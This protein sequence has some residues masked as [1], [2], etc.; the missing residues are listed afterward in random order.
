[1]K[2]PLYKSVNFSHKNLLNILWIFILGLVLVAC[3]IDKP[4]QA[5]T[6]SGFTMGTSYT[7]TIV[8]NQAEPIAASLINSTLEDIENTMSTYRPDSELMRLNRSPIETWIEVSEPLFEILKLSEELSEL[9]QGAF[10]ITVGPLVDLWGFGANQKQLNTLPSAEEVDVAKINI[11]HKNLILSEDRHAVKKLQEIKLD[12]SAIAKGYAVDA[13]ANLLDAESIE[14]Y[15]VEIGGEIRSKGRNNTN[16][17]WSIAIESPESNQ[18][19][20]ES[21]RIIFVNEIAMATSGNYRNYHEV[22]GQHYS[23]II[24]PSSASPVLSNLH[25]VTVIAESSARA[26]A[27]A[28]ALSV[29]GAEKS[30]S[31]AS[32]NNIAVYFL[33]KENNSLNEYYSELFADYLN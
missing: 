8:S 4:D 25:S 9:S 18:L 33:I 16:N 24:N 31:F 2:N 17:F 21:Q 15:L 1:M 6:L 12:L 30:I 13:L 28:T 23:H 20:Q 5:R 14:N 27:L 11:S 3:D 26:D 10:D 29:M 22:D 7:I 19:S 32:K